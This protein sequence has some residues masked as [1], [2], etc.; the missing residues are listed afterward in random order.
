MGLRIFCLDESAPIPR[1]TI[2]ELTCDGNH[3]FFSIKPQRFDH[4]E[5]FIVQRHAATKIGWLE[6]TVNERRLF[7][8]SNCRHK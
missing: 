3:G 7:F 4:P 8:C 2:L 6:K 1:D 5:G